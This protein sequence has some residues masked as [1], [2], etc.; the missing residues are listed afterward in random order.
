MKPYTWVAIFGIG[1]AIFS[2]GTV[3]ASYFQ[4]RSSSEKSSN[5]LIKT[6]KG[7][8]VGE[9]SNARIIELESELALVR[10]QLTQAR[11]ENRTLHKSLGVQASII[12]NNIT[13][14]SSTCYLR[15]FM[16]DGKVN[17]ILSADGTYPIR[18]L[19]ITLKNT[20]TN[21]I[22]ERRFNSI[23][24][25]TAG[26]LLW[27][28][29]FSEQNSQFSAFISTFNNEWSEQAVIKHA[30]SR[31]SNAPFVDSF[32]RVYKFPGWRESQDKIATIRNERI[33]G[34]GEIDWARYPIHLTA[35]GE[36]N[37]SLK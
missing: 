15:F 28:F 24:I 5:I 22:F 31:R 11:E 34:V 7:L 2:I 35:T 1:A 16:Y 4:N 33:Q 37:L 32:Y 21:E 19:E 10:A 18:E 25:S 20:I 23:K 13:G 12:E 26:K 3:V 30:T 14:G 6:E 36:Y 27:S 9:N 8:E 29:P 17:V